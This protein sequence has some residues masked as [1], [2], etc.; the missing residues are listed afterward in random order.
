[1][2]NDKPEPSKS[3]R[4]TKQLAA[5]AHHEAGH[6]VADSKFGFKIKQ[7]TIVPSDEAVGSA[8]TKGL[9]LR[10]LEYE[11]P[12]RKRIGYCHDLIISLLAGAEAQ[13][14][15]DPKSIRRHHAVGDYQSAKEV[16]IRLHGDTEEVCVQIS[17]RKGT[18]FHQQP[19]KLATD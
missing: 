10:W 2:T 3:T 12:T 7:V 5:T 19:N 15:F 4:L 6:A 14:R 11:K 18:E 16:L 17:P 8:R 9:Q 1:M 13:R